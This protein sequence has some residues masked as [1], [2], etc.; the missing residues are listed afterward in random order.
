ME[1]Q[2]MMGYVQNHLQLAILKIA[3]LETKCQVRE[4]IHFSFKETFKLQEVLITPT[5]PPIL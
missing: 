2:H 1:E 4:L 3:T 5:H